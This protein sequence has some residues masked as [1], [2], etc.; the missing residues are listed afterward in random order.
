MFIKR[1]ISTVIITYE[2]QSEKYCRLSTFFL[3]HVMRYEMVHYDDIVGITMDFL[4]YLCKN[5]TIMSLNLANQ[6]IQ[7]CGRKLDIVFEGGLLNGFIP[8]LEALKLDRQLTRGIVAYVKKY[9]S[10]NFKHTNPIPQH[11]ADRPSPN[12]GY[13]HSF[14]LYAYLEHPVDSRLALSGVDP[15][16][17]GLH[18]LTPIITPIGLNDKSLQIIGSCMTGTDRR[19][20]LTTRMSKVL[21]MFDVAREQEDEERAELAR[22][23][24]EA[25]EEGDKE[26]DADADK[27]DEVKEEKDYRAQKAQFL[28]DMEEMHQM[29]LNQL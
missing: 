3:A 10:S 2:F 5:K 20:L 11:L 7:T 29:F 9:V 22:A 21:V 26:D 8:K 4:T 13:R 15:T 18:K 16:E 14:K 24:A 1:L 28:K 23:N 6:Y 25:E 12:T 27:K 19:E 17:D